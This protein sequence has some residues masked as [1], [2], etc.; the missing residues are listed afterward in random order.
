MIDYKD[1]IP[2][3]IRL[4]TPAFEGRFSIYGN[5]FPDHV[6]SPAVLI[7]TVGGTD[8]YRLQLLARAE[9]D[10][11]AMETL[12]DVMNYLERYGNNVDGIQTLWCERESNPIPDTDEDT[13][14]PQAWCYMRLESM[15]AQM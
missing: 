11:T 2:P 9:S 10:I 6:G 4:L 14:K 5:R 12:I 1:P 13:G 15:E 8:Y 7:R 3:V